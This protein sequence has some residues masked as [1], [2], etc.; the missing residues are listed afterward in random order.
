MCDAYVCVLVCVCVFVS[1]CVGGGMG[2]GGGRVGVGG[3][4][5]GLCVCKYMFERANVTFCLVV[6]VIRIDKGRHL[7]N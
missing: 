3:R 6:L 2:D 1:V 5:I 4:E 7:M